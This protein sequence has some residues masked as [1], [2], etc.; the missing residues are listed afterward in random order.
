MPQKPSDL[1]G[2]NEDDDSDDNDKEQYIVNGMFGNEDNTS[3]VRVVLESQDTK[4]IEICD[5]II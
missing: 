3:I 4:N 2:D 1:G 5:R